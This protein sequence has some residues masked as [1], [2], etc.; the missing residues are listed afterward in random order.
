[1]K[2][3]ILQKKTQS[4]SV[5]AMENIKRILFRR[6]SKDFKGYRFGDSWLP[7][8]NFAL[9]LGKNRSKENKFGCLLCSLIRFNFELKL[10]VV[11]AR[12]FAHRMI[13]FTLLNSNRR[14]RNVFQLTAAIMKLYRHSG[15]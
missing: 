13:H 3:R 1:M 9:L 11:A 4:N 7:G 6:R 10:F 15:G 5:N 12:L 14:K 2:K 8:K